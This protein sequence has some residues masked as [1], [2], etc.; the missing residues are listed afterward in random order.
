LTFFSIIYNGLL[1]R[2]Q[3]GLIE[4]WLI[5]GFMPLGLIAEMNY[6]HNFEILM[7]FVSFAA[8]ST[9]L[10]RNANGMNDV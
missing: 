1:R 4:V 8:A 5:L 10:M 9:V 3:F 6:K 7:F 2:T